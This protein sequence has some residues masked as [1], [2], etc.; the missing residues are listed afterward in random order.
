[1]STSALY[2]PNVLV[3]QYAD[4]TGCFYQLSVFPCVKIAFINQKDIVKYLLTV[5]DK[6]QK[7]VKSCAPFCP[8]SKSRAFF[9]TTAPALQLLPG[10]VA[11]PVEKLVLKRDRVV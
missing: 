5:T 10:T 7:N 4:S 11:N 2:L 9:F 1:M 6:P 8:S 3:K